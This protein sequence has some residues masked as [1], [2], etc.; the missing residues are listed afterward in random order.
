MEEIRT[1]GHQFVGKEAKE[2]PKADPKRPKKSGFSCLPCTTV[3][4]S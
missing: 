3:K 1:E 4:K 2:K